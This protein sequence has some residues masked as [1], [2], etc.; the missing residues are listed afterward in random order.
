MRPLLLAAILLLAAAP[1]A[2]ARGTFVEPV[3]VVHTLVG[4]DPGG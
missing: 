3:R 4:D 2:E 1:A